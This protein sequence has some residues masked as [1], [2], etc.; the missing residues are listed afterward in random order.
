MKHSLQE[1]SLKDGAA[2]EES[3]RSRSPSSSMVFKT[4][5]EFISI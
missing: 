2:K 1:D 3:L 4:S 5:C